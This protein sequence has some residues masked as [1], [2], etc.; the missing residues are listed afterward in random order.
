MRGDP[1]QRHTT[2]SC[3]G[4]V[5]G[6]SRWVQGRLALGLPVPVGLAAT[7]SQAG[8]TAYRLI[9][10]PVPHED[11]HEIP[12][13]DDELDLCAAAPVARPWAAHFIQ[14][15]LE[16]LTGDRPS[17]QLIRWTSD[18]VYTALTRHVT[19]TARRLPSPQAGSAPV[20]TRTVRISYPQPAVAEVSAV[21]QCGTG[22]HAVALRLE[23]WRGSWRCTAA[24]FA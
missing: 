5:G 7:G 10:D 20:R 3:D 15:L 13:P 18:D 4:P 14:A 24:E 22:L 11:P 21:V 16:V 1:Q 23:A 9:A 17:N 2:R 12:D 19:A 6:E 8:Q